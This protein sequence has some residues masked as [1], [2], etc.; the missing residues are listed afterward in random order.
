MIVAYCLANYF[1]WSSIKKAH[2]Q[3]NNVFVYVY[4]ALLLLY[5]LSI[6]L[7]YSSLIS[8][9]FS[10][11]M[12]FN[13]STDE[14]ASIVL[15]TASIALITF[16]FCLRNFPI[17]RESNVYC[18]VPKVKKSIILYVI[19]FPIAFYYN[20]NSNWSTGE[21][22]ESASMAAYMRNILTV[23]SV[24]IFLT[25]SIKQKWKL[26]VLLLFMVVTFVSTQRTNALILIVAFVYNM[27]PTKKTMMF[28]IAGIVALLVLGS[29]R[30][31]EDFTNLL[32]PIFGEGLLGSHGL[33]QAIEYTS[34]KGYSI[35]QFF[36]LFNGSINWFLDIVR[37]GGNLPT[38]EDL[39]SSSGR[40]Y[41]PMGGFFYLSD[42]YLMH[43]I[44]GPI[45]YTLLIFWI[46][47]KSVNTFYRIHSPLSLICLSLLF[48]TVKGS[49]A[50]FTALI[51]FHY[52][53]Y[54]LLNM[55]QKGKNE[56]SLIV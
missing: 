3:I 14:I 45:V 33:V 27:K 9:R 23:L 40:I 13:R 51:V 38:F 22:A 19:F 2:L 16:A 35:S 46:Y 29:I 39:I 7:T 47:R 12:S 34:S 5:P 18:S 42:A 1:F 37:I 20:L 15:Q 28:I 36:M 48:D 32:Y 11:N 55:R 25:K 54:Y 41:Y 21:G 52:L 26:L 10:E 43:P 6:Y 56:S 31:G 49:L 17:I 50:T 8:T 30:N 4:W 53:F 24:A 44:L